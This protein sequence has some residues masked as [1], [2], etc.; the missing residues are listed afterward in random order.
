MLRTGVQLARAGF[1]LKLFWLL[2][3]CM[4]ATKA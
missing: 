4:P 1:A 3:E 2:R